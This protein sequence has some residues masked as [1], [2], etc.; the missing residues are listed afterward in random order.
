MIKWFSLL[1]A[2][3]SI[4]ICQKYDLAELVIGKRGTDSYRVWIYFS[5]KDGSAPI[6]LSEKTLDRRAKNGIKN[7][8][9]WYDF[10][11]PC[12]YID[13]LSSK[14]I[15]VI[16]KS[17]W[18]NAVSALCSK[19]DLIK[20]ENLHYTNYGYNKNILKGKVFDNKFTT[21]ISNNFDNFSM[22]L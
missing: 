3:Q 21:K 4:I 7:D 11:I 2:F 14:G 13:Q 1:I 15:N 17:R 20:I 9:L 8:I 19:S 5:D 18:L 16:N 22:V 6:T 12:K 10:N